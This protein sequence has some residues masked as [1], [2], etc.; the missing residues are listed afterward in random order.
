MSPRKAM[1]MDR[2]FVVLPDQMAGSLGAEVA[3]TLLVAAIAMLGAS[4][5]LAVPRLERL[6]RG[7]P[8]NDNEAGEGAARV[9]L[10]AV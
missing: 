3:A 1:G 9:R 10:R 4:L 7:R 2:Q 8:A 6:V 5:L